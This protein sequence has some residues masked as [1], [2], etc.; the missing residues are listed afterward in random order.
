MV[1]L[2]ESLLSVS[3]VRR[4]SILNVALTLGHTSTEQL[5]VNSIWNLE[6]S[7]N[8]L[9]AIANA[10]NGANNTKAAGLYRGLLADINKSYKGGI[11]EKDA[12]AMKQKCN[13]VYAG[14][15]SADPTFDVEAEN[16]KLEE[17]MSKGVKQGKRSK[18]IAL[19][20]MLVFVFIAVFVIV[21]VSIGSC[22]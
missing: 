15:K 1:T 6:Y 11:S 18:A 2:A 10:Y 14:L 3:Q 12:Q 21:G 9:L 20:I 19:I 7:P 22:S 4:V 13:L 16:K 8:K 17:Q 5:Y